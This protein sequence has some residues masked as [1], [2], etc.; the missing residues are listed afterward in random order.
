M[1]FL[2]LFFPIRWFYLKWE[3]SRTFCL[4]GS[5]TL[6]RGK[7]WECKWGKQTRTVAHK[8]ERRMRTDWIPDWEEKEE[9]LLEFR[10]QDYVGGGAITTE[11]STS[12]IEQT[13]SS[14]SC[15]Y[16][17]IQ[18]TLWTQKKLKDKHYVFSFLSSS[19]KRYQ[20]RFTCRATRG[21]I[22]LQGQEEP[23]P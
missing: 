13:L 2:F 11:Y 15:G 4:N 5:S 12:S 23:C 17:W 18:P 14:C 1:C 21:R 20:S 7:G 8:K 22:A 3:P 6:K 19:H 10:G 16:C 9:K